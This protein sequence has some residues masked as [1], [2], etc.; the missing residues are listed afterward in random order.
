MYIQPVPPLPLTLP[1]LQDSAD[2]QK[3]L[4]C[5]EEGSMLEVDAPKKDMFDTSKTYYLD[6]LKFT[7]TK[8]QT[9]KDKIKVCLQF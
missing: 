1:P 6:P 9:V 4:V 3:L 7:C 2:E 8:F 5:C